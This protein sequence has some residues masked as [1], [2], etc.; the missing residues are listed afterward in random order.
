M[1]TTT[2]KLDLAAFLADREADIL[3]QAKA[4]LCQARLPHY[5]TTPDKN[6]ERL[7][8]L[9]DLVVLCIRNRALLPMVTFAEQLAN[10]RY[11]SGFDLSEVQTAFNILEEV[12]W[13]E[14]T[15]GLAP[16]SYPQA[17]G[18]S[19]AVLG[20]GK[21]ALA[22]EYVSLASK[23]RIPSLDIIELFKG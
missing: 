7:R 3:A 9:F 20:A 15:K 2:V 23:R 13:A 12:V 8:R 22:R 6:L 1:T 16:A 18:V 10:E 17:F 21:Q 19:S 4:R 14:I 5:D 11:S